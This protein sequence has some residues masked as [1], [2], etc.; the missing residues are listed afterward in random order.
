MWHGEVKSGE[1]G[2]FLTC[3]DCLGQKED[4]MD[5]NVWQRQERYRG[6]KG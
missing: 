3:E 5:K 1:R 4:L 6:E 2:G